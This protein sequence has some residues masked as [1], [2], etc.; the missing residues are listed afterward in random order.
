MTRRLHRGSFLG[1]CLFS[2]LCISFVTSLCGCPSKVPDKSGATA[3]PAAQ[4]AIPAGGVHGAKV[5]LVHSYHPEYPWVNAITKGVRSGLEGT[6]TE[7]EIFYMDTKR[8]TDEAWAIQAG[9]LAEQKVNEYKPDIVITADDNAQQYFAMKY[10]DGTLPI[11]FCGVNADPSKY[12]FP[13]SNATGI[14]ER[15]HFAQTLSYI[16]SFHP[17]RRIAVLSCDDVTSSSALG[18]MKQERIDEEVTEWA[19]TNDYDTWKEKILHYNDTVDAVCIYMYHTLKAGDNPDSLDPVAVAKWTTEN[20]KVPTLG[21]FEFSVQDGMLMGV[22]ESG[23]E[24][25]EKAAAYVTAI[26]QGTPVST[27]PVITANVG[28]RMVNTKTAARIGI[29][30]TSGIIENAL[31]VT[32][33]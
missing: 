9:Q 29:P 26:L 4:P 22:A 18:F 15:P 17:I 2:L 23:F 33:E 28:T 12:G 19:L 30:L 32:G 8:N 16:K 25:G 20:A 10:L 11:V 24:H 21:F 1:I 31:V 7:L 5:L 27:L 3:Q 13:A 14:I 6:G